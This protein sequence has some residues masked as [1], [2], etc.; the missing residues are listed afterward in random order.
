MTLEE[1]YNGKIK[2]FKI[3]QTRI[4]CP[5]GMSKE[6][7]CQQCATCDGNGMVVQIR[8]MGPMI[9]QMQTACPDC[10]GTGVNIKPGVRQVQQKKM[11]EVHIEKGMKNGSQIKL[12]GEGD[13][14]PGMLPGD[15]VFVLKEKQHEVF[16]RKG[17]DLLIQ[18]K[19]TLCEALTGV[20]FTVDHLDGRELLVESKEGGIIEHQS[21]MAID[22][23]GMPFHGNPFTKGRL[24][25]LFEVA[26]PK[27]ETLTGPQ[28]Q[29][30]KTVLPGGEPCDPSED[31]EP[32]VLEPV[33]VESFGK[34]G[35]GAGP[36][37]YDSDEEGGPGGQQ[38]VQCA[39]Q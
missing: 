2:R 28:L 26:F 3:S 1:F 8:R 16:K 14:K 30:L 11:L 27:P 39:Q 33:S 23:E 35:P 18:K 22:S 13:E 10:R 24:F 9:Q 36:S 7:A 32:C 19:I 25:I 5:A 12:D 17:N 31:A 38:R 15:I 37:A 4:K 29:V 6:D 21:V 20:K 34:S